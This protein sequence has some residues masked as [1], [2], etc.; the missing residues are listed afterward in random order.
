MDHHR[1]PPDWNAPDGKDSGLFAE[2]DGC[3]RDHS[4]LRYPQ[5]LFGYCMPATLG[6]EALLQNLP[7]LKE[8]LLTKVK[9]RQKLM[10]AHY[11]SCNQVVAA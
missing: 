7:Q 4:C 1:L 9:S 5:A 8:R 6:L 3:S 2:Q 11:G 10:E